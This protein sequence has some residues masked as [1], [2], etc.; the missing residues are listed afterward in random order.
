MFMHEVISLNNDFM[1]WLATSCM[2]ALTE[3]SQSITNDVADSEYCL[4]MRNL[5]VRYDW[6]YLKH[7]EIDSIIVCR[8]GLIKLVNFAKEDVQ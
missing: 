4:R 5:W 1:T 2:L 3:V 6:L 7:Q 8:P